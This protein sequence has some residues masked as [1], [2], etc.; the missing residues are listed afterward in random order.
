[1]QTAAGIRE[2][3]SVFGDDYNTPDGS[4]IRDYI[5]VVDL[6]L[7]HVKA[8]K[9]LL[10]HKQ[11]SAFEVFNLG[12]GKGLSVFEIIKAFEKTTGEKLN[13]KVVGRREGDIEKV[14]ADTSYANSE[15]GWRAEKGIEETL[16]SAWNWEMNIRSKNKRT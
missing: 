3:L 7:A 14:Y 13:Y 6:A 4:A 10:D 2:S 12:T 8:I 16:Q 15:L 11:L 9:R 1:M 5:N